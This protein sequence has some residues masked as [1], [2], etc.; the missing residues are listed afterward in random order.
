MKLKCKVSASVSAGAKNEN[1][2]AFSLVPANEMFVYPL[3]VWKLCRVSGEVVSAVN[4]D[5]N[6]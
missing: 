3:Y 6:K 5:T 4:E 2:P 1:N